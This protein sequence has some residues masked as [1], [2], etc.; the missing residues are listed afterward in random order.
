MNN[1]ENLYYLFIY[2]VLRV[3]VLNWVVSYILNLD[4]EVEFLN[5]VLYIIIG[6]LY[7]RVC[8]NFLDFFYRIK[9]KLL[10]CF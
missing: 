10:V 1:D 7:V 4:I 5:L 3:V 2:Y 9:I 6:G 8:V